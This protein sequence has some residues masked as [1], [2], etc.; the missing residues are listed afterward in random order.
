MANQNKHFLTK[1]TF[2]K[3]S[4]PTFS[5]GRKS[6]LADQTLLFLTASVKHL[7]VITPTDVMA[8][9]AVM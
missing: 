8:I 9:G 6:L 5:K 4:R 3:D 7:A 2:N 1:V